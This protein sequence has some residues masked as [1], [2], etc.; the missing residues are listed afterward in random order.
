MFFVWLVVFVSFKYKTLN[1]GH[2]TSL[3][4]SIAQVY[5]CL[6]RHTRQDH[7]CTRKSDSSFPHS[8]QRAHL[9]KYFIPENKTK[10]NKSSAWVSLPF[11][12]WKKNVCRITLPKSLSDLMDVV[13]SD[14]AWCSTCMLNTQLQL[15]GLLTA[16]QEWSG[17][18][19]VYT[20]CCLW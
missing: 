4:M 9:V 1:M 16:F 7:V 14:T 3:C 15:F 8:W 5:L 13:L 12:V 19:L 2:L 10:Q 17:A 6:S 20:K 18:L 11:L